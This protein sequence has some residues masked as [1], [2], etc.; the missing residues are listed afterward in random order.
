ME[1]YEIAMVIFVNR[2]DFFVSDNTPQGVSHI[3]YYGKCPLN[4]R[5][6]R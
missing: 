6:G 4:Q 5:M 3:S 2:Y 1:P